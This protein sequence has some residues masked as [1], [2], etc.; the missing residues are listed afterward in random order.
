MEKSIKFY[1]ANS[2]ARLADSMLMNRMPRA[3]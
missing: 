2:F 3:T 1:V